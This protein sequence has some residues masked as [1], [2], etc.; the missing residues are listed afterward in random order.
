MPKCS[1]SNP[2][3][4]RKVIDVPAIILALCLTAC[5]WHGGCLREENAQNIEGY[6]KM[7]LPVKYEPQG[8]AEMYSMSSESGV[9][10]QGLGR[11]EGTPAANASENIEGNV[12]GQTVKT[13]PET[14]G[15]YIV[16]TGEG[17]SEIAA[18]DEV[19]GDPLKWP[20]LYFYNMNKIGELQLV[21]GFL[22]RSLAEGESL[23]IITA[24]EARENLQQRSGRA[25]AVN[26]LSARSQKGL[27]SSAIR[28]MREGYPVYITSAEIDGVRWMRLRVGFFETKIEASLQRMKINDLL[29]IHNSWVTETEQEEIEEFGGL[30]PRFHKSE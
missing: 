30:I 26:V 28:L 29:R 19:Y 11:T 21:D 13:Q 25:Y 18:S 2:M 6:Q 5:L 8:I 16:K 15:A 12:N 17:L 20:I 9:K 7:R 1:Y 4:R 10:S 27:I 22:K 14:Q 3:K 23:R 24:R